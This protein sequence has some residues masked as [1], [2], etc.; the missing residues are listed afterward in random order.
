M[1]TAPRPGASPD[2]GR[3]VA[4]AGGG[5]QFG[6]FELPF[7]LPGDSGPSGLPI[8]GVPLPGLKLGFK[9]D[10]KGHIQVSA[11]MF[12]YTPFKVDVDPDYAL[13]GGYGKRIEADMRDPAKALLSGDVSYH[14][15][16]VSVPPLDVT[17]TDFAQ[18]FSWLSAKVV[19]PNHIHLGGRYRTKGEGLPFHAEVK[20]T[21]IANGVYEFDI[22][23]LRLGSWN[24]P[25]PSF[26]A[27]FCSWFMLKVLR[28]MDGVT[29]A[30]FGK[31]RVDLRAAAESVQGRG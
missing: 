11:S 26:L 12:G 22:R 23:A 4:P 31:L 29:M 15:I 3:P 20:S 13:A 8:P 6:G 28:G 19:E 7:K 21:K 14:G 27:S 18:A 25:I 24:I 2:A 16:P 10:S 5:F 30:G 1:P 17:G 9:V